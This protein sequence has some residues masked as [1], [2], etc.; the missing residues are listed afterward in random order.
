MT[1]SFSEKYFTL[2]SSQA[3]NPLPVTWLYFQGETRDDAHTLTWATASERNNDYFELERSI[4]TK[5]WHTVAEIRGAGYSNEQL[6]YRYV[7]R[8]APYGRV[9]YRVRQVDFDGMNEIHHKLVSLERKR[10]ANMAEMEFV[11]YPN[12]TSDQS[13]R[14]LLPG[15]ED[16]I[17]Q[18]S[19]SDMS[20][21]IL[22]QEKIQIDSQSI[23]ESIVCNFQPGVYLVTVIADGDMKSKPLVIIK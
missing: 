20:G 11:L 21:K 23:S 3:I 7:D 15:Y 4:D 8:D 13:V 14:I 12:P 10:E 1:S 19:L 22:S 18:I 2:G 16:A 5:N 6:E 9:Y 17:V